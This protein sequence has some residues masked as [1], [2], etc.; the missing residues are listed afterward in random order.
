MKTAG[1]AVGPLLTQAT[2]RTRGTVEVNSDPAGAEVII[3]GKVAGRTPY[4]ATRWAGSYPVKVQLPGRP[5][6]ESVLKVQAGEPL[7][8][9]AQ[10]PSASKPDE[11]P[12]VKPTA[13]PEPPPL[14]FRIVGAELRAGER[15]DALR[16]Q[17]DRHAGD[18]GYALLLKRWR[19]GR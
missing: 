2:G 19:A 15:S 8:L 7:Q 6:F 5:P 16:T 10:L 17:L 13:K 9:T 14:P 1:Q 12:T 11:K 18:Y 4:R 3:D